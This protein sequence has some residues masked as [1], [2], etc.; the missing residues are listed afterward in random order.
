MFLMGRVNA[1]RV[2]KL[3]KSAYNKKGRG[4]AMAE[5]ANC[6]RCDTVFA[7]RIREICQ[8]CY[9]EEERAFETVYRF[10]MK[11]VNREATLQEIVQAT[12]VD[13]EKI[14][15]F[16][17]EKRLRTAQFPMLAYPCE[18]CDVPIIS[19]KLCNTCS[20]DILNDLKQHEAITQQA[21]EKEKNAVYY[22]IDTNKK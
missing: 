7:K 11:R 2:P 12:T 21:E 17:K 9:L 20:Q 5:L 16:I 15:K 8:A 3:T 4:C 22:A 18:K 13:E 19:G 6:V 1:V 10:L 14:I